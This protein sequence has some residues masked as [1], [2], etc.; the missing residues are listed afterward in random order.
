MFQTENQ[1]S[2]YL[3]AR[4]LFERTGRDQATEGVALTTTMALLHLQTLRAQRLR[5][6]V[7]WGARQKHPSKLQKNQLPNQTW[8]GW[9]S[10]DPTWQLS[11]C[12]CLH[13]YTCTTILSTL[14]PKNKHRGFVV[15]FLN[16]E[17]CPKQ[18]KKFPILNIRNC[19]LPLT[20]VFRKEENTYIPLN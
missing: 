1:C 20:S 6:A 10:R 5:N 4:F 19:F 11:E 13:C 3:A 18:P 9:V 16:S 8:S 12:I 15:S 17:P 14:P 7:Q 2:P